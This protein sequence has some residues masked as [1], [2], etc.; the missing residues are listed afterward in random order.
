MIDVELELASSIMESLSKFNWSN[1]NKFPLELLFLLK[2]LLNLANA[3]QT[4]KNS[5]TF[6]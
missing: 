3:I 5:T 6:L 1:C 4:L 2:A